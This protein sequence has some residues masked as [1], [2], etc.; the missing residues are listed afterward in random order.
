MVKWSLPRPIG[1]WGKGSPVPHRLPGRARTAAAIASAL[2]FVL[3]QAALLSGLVAPLAPASPAAAFSTK[4]TRYPY[5]TDVVTSNAT[6]NWATD[7]SATTGSVKYGVAGGTCATRTVTA[8]KTAI[9]VGATTQTQY[10]WKAQLTGLATGTQYCYKV[11][12]GT[13]DLLAGDPTPTFWSQIAAGGPSSYSFGVIGDWGALNGTSTNPDQA[14]LMSRIATSGIRFMVSTGDAAYPSGSQLNYGDLAQTGV[15]TSAVFGPSFWKVVG[16][17]IPMFNTVGNHGF[18]A[19]GLTMWPEAKAASTSG[20]KYLSETYCCTNG[21]TSASLPSAWYAFDVGNARFYVLTASWN[22]NNG[23]ANSYQNDYDN[24]WTQASA[25]YQW[26]KNDLKTHPTALKFAFFHF[27]MYSGNNTEQSDVLLRGANSLEGLLASYGVDIAFSGHAH[28]YQRNGAPTTANIV[29]YVTGGG[30]AKLEPANTCGEVRGGGVALGRSSNGISKCGTFTTPGTAIGDV[31]HFLKVTVNNNLVTVTPTTANGGTFDSKSYTFSGGNDTTPPTAPTNLTADAGGPDHVTLSW[32]TSTDNVG[33]AGYDIYRN[34]VLLASVGNPPSGTTMTYSDDTA[35]GSTTYSYYVVARDI[36]GNASPPSNTA[37]VTTPAPDPTLVFN[38]TDDTYIQKSSPTVT[39]GTATTLQIDNSPVKD[40][41]MKFNVTGLTGK[42]ITGAKLRL[43]NTDPSAKGGDFFV[44]ASTPSWTEATANWNNAPAKVGPAFASLGAVTANNWYTVDLSTV[45]TGDGVVNLRVSS[46]SSDGANYAS[47][48]A[49]AAN[50]PQLV[51]SYAPPDTE[52]PTAPTGVTATP[53]TSTSVNLAWTA[54]TDN[55]GVT[56]YN[57][58][59]NG[60]ATPIGTSTTTTFTDSAAVPGFDNSYTVTALDAANNESA[61]ST[62][63]ATALTPPAAPT[64]LT[65]AGGAGSITLNWTASAGAT[66][67]SVYRGITAGGEETTPTG[68]TVGV[69]STSFT[70]FTVVPGIQYFYKVTA[71][72]GSPAGDGPPSNEAFA[73][74]S[75]SGPAPSAPSGLSAVAGTGS[76]VDLTWNN[77]APDPATS[78]SVKRATTTGGPYATVK[79]GVVPGATSSSYTDTPVPA[80]GTYYYVVTGVN[81]NGESGPSNEAPITLPP[82]APAGLT[83]TPG[84][85][86]VALR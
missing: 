15:D 16:A 33:V 45:V 59:R 8:T 37:T 86:Q 58:Y 81:A 85:N 77:S 7:R 47:R 56:G 66:G 52:K 67:Y 13:T 42:S 60:G 76:S 31:M 14:N 30:G 28:I 20:G 35:V 71:T 39:A 23:T 25:Q 41:L 70:D 79:S 51:V 27:P 4:L 49:A 43:W 74:A 22:T 1:V 29:N 65:A 17:K 9:I 84:D 34:G 53:V 24:H 73:A 82:A 38:P 44:A 62:P 83:A 26:L 55:V 11:F 68:T 54:S 63:A 18:N 57:I 12:L 64:S 19:T 69:G 50:R 21:T 48:Q 5:L 61:Q 2:I 32:T 75:A 3:S 6:V 46:N 10:Q 80:G 78:Y 40:V 36:A 72:N